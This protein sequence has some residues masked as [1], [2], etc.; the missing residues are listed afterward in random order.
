VARRRKKSAP[1]PRLAAALARLQLP[2]QLQAQAPML[3]ATLL[4]RAAKALR[5][6]AALAKLLLQKRNNRFTPIPQKPSLLGFCISRRLHL[7][8]ILLKYCHF[9]LEMHFSNSKFPFGRLMK[10]S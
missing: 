8:S 9:E 3:A 10:I 6:S 7:F 5:K 1:P 2:V 4:P